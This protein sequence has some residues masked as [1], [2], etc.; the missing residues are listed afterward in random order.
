VS[1]LKAVTTASNGQNIIGTNAVITL[2]GCEA[3]LNWYDHYVFQYTCIAQLVSTNTQRGVYAYKDGE[4]AS[5]NPAATATSKDYTGEPDPIP[6]TIPLYM[7][8]LGTPGKKP[9]PLPFLPGGNC[10]NPTQ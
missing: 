3:G 9:A 4:Y 10:P 5:L 2:N 8:P 1:Q 6:F 7:I